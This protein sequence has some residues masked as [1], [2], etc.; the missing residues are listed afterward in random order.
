M[1]H[2]ANGIVFKRTTVVVSVKMALKKRVFLSPKSFV[3]R[4]K[5]P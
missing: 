3:T 4:V 1:Y 2:I 5:A